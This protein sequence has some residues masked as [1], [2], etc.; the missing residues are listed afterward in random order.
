MTGLFQCTVPE[1]M[2]A[3]DQ[4]TVDVPGQGQY[5]LTVPPNHQAGATFNFK[6]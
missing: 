6:V 2:G 1:G 3:G 5:H 4:L